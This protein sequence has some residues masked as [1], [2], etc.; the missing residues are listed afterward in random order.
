MSI[1]RSSYS[2]HGILKEEMANIDPQN[3]DDILIGLEE[4][5]RKFYG[6]QA[7]QPDPDIWII[8]REW[9]RIKGIQ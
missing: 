4:S 3:P 2:F 7:G 5:Y 8:A 1:F 6:V 9:L